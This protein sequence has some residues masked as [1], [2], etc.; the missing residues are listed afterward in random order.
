MEL[1]VW[2]AVGSDKSR[3]GRV[4]TILEF[5]LDDSGWL[6]MAQEMKNAERGDNAG[7]VPSGGLDPSHRPKSMFIGVL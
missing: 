7:E 4:L 3:A 1:R 5:S 6:A 2:D